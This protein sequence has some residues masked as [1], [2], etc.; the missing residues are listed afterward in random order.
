MCAVYINHLRSAQLAT[1]L[2][3][4]W[5]ST[6]RVLAMPLFLALLLGPVLVVAHDIGQQWL[7]AC[8]DP[9]EVMVQGD[10]HNIIEAN[11]RIG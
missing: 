7:G 8:E 2:V 9:A 3:A 1:D 5:L 11:L 10:D 4:L 6:F